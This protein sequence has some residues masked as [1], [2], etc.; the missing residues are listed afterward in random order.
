MPDEPAFDREIGGERRLRVDRLVATLADAQHGVVARRQL[1]DAGLGK[2]AIDH[3]VGCGRLH[4][5]HRGVYAVGRSSLSREGRWMAA[6][7]AGG[8]GAAL[9]HRSAA[10]LW[11]LLSPGNRAPEVTVPRWRRRRKPVEIAWH[12]GALPPDDNDLQCNPCDDGPAHAPGSRRGPRSSGN[13]EGTQRGRGPRLPRSPITPRSPCA[14]PPAPRRRDDPGPP[15]GRRDRCHA[16]EERTRGALSSLPRERRAAK[17]L[18]ERP[19]SSWAIGSSRRIA[20]GGGSGWS[21][22]STA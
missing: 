15:A 8:E 11:G 12:S 13:G 7:L 17:T 2:D 19:P 6:V 9:S 1:R 3:R 10:E 22:S 14:L 4:V 5:A 18:P 16:D 21:S 20:Y